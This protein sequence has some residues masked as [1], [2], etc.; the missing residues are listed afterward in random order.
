MS[1]V[2]E[3]QHT[4][5]NKQSSDIFETRVCMKDKRSNSTRDMSLLALLS[6]LDSKISFIRRE[7]E[8]FLQGLVIYYICIFFIIRL[9]KSLVNFFALH[10]L[11]THLLCESSWL[12]FSSMCVTCLYLCLLIKLT[13]KQLTYTLNQLK[14]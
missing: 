14:L 6:L 12:L 13:S 5:G 10:S 3:E 4:L 8:I 7:R 9:R 1:L 2:Q 11:F